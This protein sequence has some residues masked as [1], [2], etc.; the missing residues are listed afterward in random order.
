[1]P[2]PHRCRYSLESRRAVHDDDARRSEVHSPVPLRM[3][4]YAT[5]SLFNC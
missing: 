1:M 3:N 4:Y 5:S 2:G